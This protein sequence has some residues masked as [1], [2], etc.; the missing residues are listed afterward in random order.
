MA[1]LSDR[2]LLVALTGLAAIAMPLAT[3][4]DPGRG[5]PVTIHA[6]AVVLAVPW[7]AYAARQ[8]GSES[9][10][11]DA[12]APVVTEADRN[13]LSQLEAGLTYAQIAERSGVSLKTTTVRI[14]RLYRHLGASNKQ[15]A[16]RF[17]RP[18]QAPLPKGDIPEPRDET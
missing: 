4:A 13:L 11:L 7:L 16:I 9:P 15:E 12:T 5:I 6:T 3:L 18:R 8:S 17:G 2:G 1:T 10:S 14:A